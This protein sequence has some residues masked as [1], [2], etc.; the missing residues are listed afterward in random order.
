M[1][2]TSRIY[3]IHIQMYLMATSSSI[4]IIS[5]EVGWL[6]GKGGFGGRAWHGKGWHGMGWCKDVMRDSYRIV[7]SFHPSFGVSTMAIS[8]VF[9]GNEDLSFPLKV[10]LSIIYTLHG[11]SFSTSSFLNNL[12]W[13]WPLLFINIILSFN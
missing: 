7:I 11:L 13:A 4:C 1:C 2:I 6:A 8:S 9:F 5:C 12:A 10:I 3:H